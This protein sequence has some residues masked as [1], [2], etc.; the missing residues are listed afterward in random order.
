MNNFEKYYIYLIIVILLETSRCKIESTIF[1]RKDLSIVRGQ[2]FLA[3]LVHP[4]T[5]G[6]LT[7][8]NLVLEGKVRNNVRNVCES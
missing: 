8:C 5:F 6:K 1:P 2:G 4:V 7:K 3:H